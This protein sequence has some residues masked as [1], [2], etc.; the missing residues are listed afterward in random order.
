MSLHLINNVK[1]QS[2]QQ[3]PDNLPSPVL[4]GNTSRPTYL[5]T[6]TA[7]PGNNQATGKTGCTASVKPHIWR[8]S[9][10]VNSVLH[11]CFTFRDI[12]RNCWTYCRFS[13]CTKPRCDAH[14]CQAGH[15]S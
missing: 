14:H 4:T 15:N 12:A 13:I 7:K 3:N 1:D 2:R 10:P 11:F 8:A 6:N 5:A 9:D